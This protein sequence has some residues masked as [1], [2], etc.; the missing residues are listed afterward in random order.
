LI[1]CV[2]DHR[3]SPCAFIVG[4]GAVGNPL[5]N[6]SSCRAADLDQELIVQVVEQLSEREVESGLGLRSRLH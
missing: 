6:F 3:R 2:R 4:C 5:K 1:S